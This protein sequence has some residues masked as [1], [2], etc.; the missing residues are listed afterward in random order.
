MLGGA[1]ATCDFEF[2]RD[3][4]PAPRDEE[5]KVYVGMDVH[6]DTVIVAALPEGAP[7]PGW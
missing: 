4:R 3:R 1:G 5:N 2:Q 6:K 7:E